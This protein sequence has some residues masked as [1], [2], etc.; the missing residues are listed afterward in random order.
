MILI[1]D[2]FIP[3]LLGQN[4]SASENKDIGKGHLSHI[5]E[6]LEWVYF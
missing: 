5:H 4:L 3:K 2:F 1:K 6:S